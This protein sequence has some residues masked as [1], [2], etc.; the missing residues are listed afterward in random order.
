[1]RKAAALLGFL[2]GVTGVAFGYLAVFLGGPTTGLGANGR[3]WLLLLSLAAMLLSIAGGWLG[4]TTVGGSR[5][6][7]ITLLVIGGLGF[8]CLA[9]YWIVPGALFLTSGLLL[10]ADGNGARERKRQQEG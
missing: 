8:V 2:G 1:V 6:S 5:V 4:A 7:G 10:N 9:V 3:G